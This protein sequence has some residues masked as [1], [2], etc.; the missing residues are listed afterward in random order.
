[1]GA[2]RLELLSLEGYWSNIAEKTRLLKKFVS[3]NVLVLDT[4]REK[5]RHMGDTLVPYI[6][7][8]ASRMSSSVLLFKN[9]K[10]IS[11]IAIEMRWIILYVASITLKYNFTTKS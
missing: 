8:K 1:M 9:Y 6:M 7:L 11:G 5:T 10:L 3:P 4:K 2:I